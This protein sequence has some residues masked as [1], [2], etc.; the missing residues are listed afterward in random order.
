MEIQTRPEFREKASLF[1][2]RRTARDSNRA[3]RFF[4]MTKRNRR[5]LIL[6]GVAALAGSSGCEKPLFPKD[7]P[8]T[9]YDRYDAIRGELPAA[10]VTDQYGNPRENVRARLLRKGY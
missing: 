7:E 1:L 6:A 4:V 9:Q 10:R 3:V 8:R 5:W 2:L